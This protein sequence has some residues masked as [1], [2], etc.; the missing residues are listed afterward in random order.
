MYFWQTQSGS[1]GHFLDPLSQ[2]N[3]DETWKNTVNMALKLFNIEND[4]H[5]K[6]Q[7]LWE[8]VKGSLSSK[9]NALGGGSD[10]R[11]MYDTFCGYSLDVVKMMTKKNLTQEVWRLQVALGEQTE[12]SKR[13]FIVGFASRRRIVLSSFPV[14][15]TYSASP[16][17]FIETLGERMFKPYLSTILQGNSKIVTITPIDS[18][19]TA[20]KKMLE[21]K[22]SLAVM[23]IENNIWKF[24]KYVESGWNAYKTTYLMNRKFRYS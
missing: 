5:E 24:M 16:N 12:M 14:G 4:K 2:R 13:R 7:S 18:V 10:M 3:R 1:L 8:I 15:T 6:K 20:A 19:L 21:F 9:I 17:T 22:I 23:T 11:H